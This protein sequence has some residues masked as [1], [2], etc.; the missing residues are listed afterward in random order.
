MSC[1][2]RRLALSFVLIGVLAASVAA[3]ATTAPTGTLTVAYATLF[4]ENLNPLLGPAP[5]K[6][7]Y[8]IMYEYLIYNDPQTLKAEPGLAER[9]SMSP[10]GKR[11][12][13]VLRKGVTFSDGTELTAEDVKFSLELLE[14]KE[15]RWPLRATFLRVEPKVLDRYTIAFDAKEGGVADLDQTFSS[16]LGLPIVS[17]AHYDK[18]GDRG[19]EEHP[20]GSG[21][22]RFKARRAG[23]SV[24]FE[25]RSDWKTHWRVGAD[26]TKHGAFKE[27]VFRKVPEVATRV[28]MLRTGEADIAELTPEVIREVERAKLPIV[29]S[30]DSYVP[31]V[32][33]HGVW[34]P[35]KA[36]YDASLP[37]LK[38]EV[39]QA[40]SLALN[41]KEI[42]EKFYFGSAAPA[43][44]PHWFHPNTLGWNPA[45]KPDQYDPARAKKL[46]ADAG[47]PNGFPI[48]LRLFTMPGTTELPALG[49]AVAGYWEKVGVK[50]DLIRTEWVVHRPDLVKRSFKGATVYRGFPQVEPVTV[51][52]LAYHSKGDFGEREDGFVDSTIDTLAATVNGK[53]REALARRLGDFLTRDAATLPIISAS[54]LYGINPKTVNSWQPTRGKYPD[55]FERAVPV[56]RAR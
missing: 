41:R 24:S 10:D 19:Y 38:K 7:F 37:W 54:Y 33:F 56:P 25:A 28:A 12:T 20:L 21:P 2:T 49:E 15:S 18:V 8:D 34:L 13:F 42:G 44:G 32:T 23:D 22:Y 3:N 45:W 31:M 4:D 11:W 9:W 51:W 55:R 27:I 14:R 17:K 26:W 40:L 5:S 53:E 35:A 16:F 52:R 46:L 50:A 43:A 6:V 36:G 1:V 39:R 47:Y 29:R 30:P 48:P